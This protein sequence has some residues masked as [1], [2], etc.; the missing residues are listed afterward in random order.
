MP[1][2]FGETETLEAHYDVPDQQKSDRYREFQPLRFIDEEQDFHA[3]HYGS[4][5]AANGSA[6]RSAEARQY[7]AKVQKD[8]QW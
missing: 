6:R 4:Q 8:Q 3:Q 2:L 7:Q 5:S 1:G